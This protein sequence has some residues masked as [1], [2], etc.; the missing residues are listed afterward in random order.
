MPQLAGV[1]VSEEVTLELIQLLVDAGHDQVAGVLV[2]ALEHE[3]RVVALTIRDRD[4]IL[5]V[6]DDQPDGLTELRGVLL[7]EREWRLREG[8]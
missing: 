6:L 4:A 5:S 8:L 1:P 3:R 7:R 2:L